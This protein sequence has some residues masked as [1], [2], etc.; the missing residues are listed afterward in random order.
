MVQNAAMQFVS[1]VAMEPP[2]TFDADSVRDEKVKVLHAL[3][4]LI[5]QDAVIN[6]IRAQYGPGWVSGHQVVGYREEPGASPRSTTQTYVA[7]QVFI[8]TWRW[9]GVPFFLR[10][11]NDLPKAVIEL[12]IQFN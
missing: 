4:P 12:A 1:L 5:G 9:A 6:I 8:D 11:G 3:Q 7:L 10:T 2:T